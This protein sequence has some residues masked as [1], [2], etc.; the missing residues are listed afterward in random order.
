MLPNTFVFDSSTSGGW[1]FRMNNSSSIPYTL[2]SCSLSDDVTIY[3]R[4]TGEEVD[5]K[6]VVLDCVISFSRSSILDTQ[7]GTGYHTDNS[8]RIYLGNIMYDSQHSGSGEMFLS[9]SYLV[10]KIM[11]F[12]VLLNL[13]IWKTVLVMVI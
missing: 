8:R 7:G 9:G 10:V 13:E 3:K 1:Y 2:E 6:Y 12:P 11:L 4:D 5:G